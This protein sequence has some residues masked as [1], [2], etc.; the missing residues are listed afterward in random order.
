MWGC[1]KDLPSCWAVNRMWGQKRKLGDESGRRAQTSTEAWG[2]IEQGGQRVRRGQLTGNFEYRVSRICRWLDVGC[3]KTR[4]IKSCPQV[5]Q[6]TQL[7]KWT[8]T[9]WT[10]GD[11]GRSRSGFG[12]ECMS[13][14][15]VMV[16]L[17]RDK[18]VKQMTAEIV[19]RLQEMSW[20]GRPEFPGL[21]QHPS[22]QWGK[23]Q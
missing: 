21:A 5:F 7:E 19:S 17:W 23:K 20:P 14:V 1:F 15:L 12:G 13:L 3:A 16:R 2:C 10:R 22:S 9:Y 11:G 18:A 4:D 8:A 6:P